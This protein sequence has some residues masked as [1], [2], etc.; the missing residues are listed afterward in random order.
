MEWDNACHK[1]FE[2]LKEKLKNEPILTYPDFS[3]PF[4]IHT[5]ASDYGIGAILIQ[6]Q[7]G[8]EKVISYASRTLNKAETSYATTE[9]ECLAI[10][11]G[12]TH[13]RPYIYGKPITVVT[14]HNP[15][16]WLMEF[17]DNSPRLLRWSLKI[18]EYDL[19]IEHRPGRNILMW[20]Y[21]QDHP[22]MT[23]L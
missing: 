15:L 19:R 13:F 7:N 14:D 10:V 9:K 17:K 22:L 20:I 23:R 18:Q 11:W 2:T 1:A 8:Q 3:K 6:E 4:K 21:Y 5:D 12:I 16:K